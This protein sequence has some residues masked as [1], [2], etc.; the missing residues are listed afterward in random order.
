MEVWL[1]EADGLVKQGEV[2]LDG[3]TGVLLLECASA[4]T[5]SSELCD[6]GYH[7]IE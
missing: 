1:D 3:A 6:V 2:D 4:F 7:K 5:L